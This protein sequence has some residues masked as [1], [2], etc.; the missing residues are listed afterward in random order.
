VFTELQE[1]LFPILNEYKDLLFTART[2]QNAA[3]IRSLYVLHAINHL[4]KYAHTPLSPLM[5]VADASATLLLTS[6]CLTRTRDNILKN[7]AKLN[8]ASEEKRAL[9]YVSRA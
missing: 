9:L 6:Y 7:S 2:S 3:E 5:L 1:G 8:A 4:L